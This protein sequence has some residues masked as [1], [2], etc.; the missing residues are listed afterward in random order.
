MITIKRNCNSSIKED[1][2]EHKMTFGAFTIKFD[3]DDY[4]AFEWLRTLLDLKSEE[5]LQELLLAGIDKLLADGWVE[6]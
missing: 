4:G 6:E 2:E 5:L 1:P 3:E